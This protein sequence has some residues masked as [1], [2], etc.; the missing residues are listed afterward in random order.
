MVLAAQPALLPSVTEAVWFASPPMDE[1]ARL[2]ALELAYEQQVRVQHATLSH[3][4]SRTRHHLNLRACVHF[5]RSC[6]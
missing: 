3:T 2:S 6:F 4:F 5:R 1:D